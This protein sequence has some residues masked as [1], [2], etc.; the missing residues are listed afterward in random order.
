MIAPAEVINFDTIVHPHHDL[1]LV[2]SNLNAVGRRAERYGLAGVAAA[3]GRV[4]E[5][6]LIVV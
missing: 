5:T 1:T 3:V 6:D 4:P 2:L